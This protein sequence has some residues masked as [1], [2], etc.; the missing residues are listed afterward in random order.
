MPRPSLSANIGDEGT[1]NGR[2]LPGVKVQVG[3]WPGPEG[4]GSVARPCVQMNSRPFSS[5]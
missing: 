2:A 1:R 3:R 5:A 4:R